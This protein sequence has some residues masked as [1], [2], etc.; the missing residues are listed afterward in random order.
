[1]SSMKIQLRKPFF[2]QNSI[3]KIQIEIGKTIKSGR[4]TLGKNLELFERDFAKYLGVRF[5]CGVSSGTAG[6]HLALLAL[7]IKSGDEVIVPAKTFI[8]TA[9]AAVYCNAR[10]VFCDVD[11]DSFQIDPDKMRKLI[12]CRTKAVIPV[13]LGGNVCE[14]DEILEIANKH[15]IDVVEDAAHAHGSTYNGKKAGTFGKIGVFS[16]YP[17]KIMASSDGGI[18]VSNNSS[19][20]EKIARLRNVGRRNLGKYDFTEIGYNYR[21]NEI[22]AILAREQLR[23]LPNMIKK[24]REIAARYN[25]EFHNI[26][27]LRIQRIMPNVRSSYYAYILRLTKGS[28]D[29]FKIQLEKKGIETSPMFISLH[30]TKPYQKMGKMYTHSYPISEMLDKQTFTIPLHPKLSNKQVDYV[31]RTI[32]EILA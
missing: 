29:R 16:L 14:M 12:T 6:L 28:L 23:L 17:D 8:S 3:K 25:L 31:V 21:M 11:E 1:M 27:K 26:E 18:V 9:N 19:L 24:R 2:P 32:K 22:Q 20:Y 30:K 4:L 13:H 5:A 15:D 7:D 10:P